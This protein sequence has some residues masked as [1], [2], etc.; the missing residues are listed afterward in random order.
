MKQIKVSDEVYEVLSTQAEKHFRTLG[1]Q[2]EYLIS[3]DAREQH[4]Q[5]EE[6]AENPEMLKPGGVIE[7]KI[8]REK[9]ILNEINKIEDDIKLN[10]GV[11]QDPDW[12]TA[13]NARKKAL[14]DEWHAITGK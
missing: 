3:L 13:A 8:P 2:V 11:N 7:Y 1:G 12:W 4:S 9:E 5:K 10:Q 6:V 14:W